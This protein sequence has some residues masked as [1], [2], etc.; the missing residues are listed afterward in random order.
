MSDFYDV[1]VN[2]E[3][4]AN[5]P[6]KVEITSPTPPYT[7]VHALVEAGTTHLSF[8]LEQV[9]ELEHLMSSALQEFASK[10]GKQA[11]ALNEH[12]WQFAQA[13]KLAQETKEREE[14]EGA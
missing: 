9:A 5:V 10:H 6:M 14:H 3:S 4:T 12:H 13:V 2:F 8:S 1:R 11:V 7:R